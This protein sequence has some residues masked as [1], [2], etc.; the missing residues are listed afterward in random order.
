MKG[1]RLRTKARFLF[2]AIS[3]VI[4]LTYEGIETTT[5]CAFA[6]LKGVPVIDLTYEGIETT[7]CLS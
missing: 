6:R 2:S 7:D 1:L 4:D 3:P 5:I